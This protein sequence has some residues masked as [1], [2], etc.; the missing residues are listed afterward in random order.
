M[1]FTAGAADG[2]EL[3]PIEFSIAA[4]DDNLVEG[5]EDFTVALSG[6]GSSTGADVTADT[7]VLTTDIEDND[8]A[9]FVISQD[10][11]SIAETG[12]TAVE[13]TISLVDPVSGSAALL[14][15]G[16]DASVTV[17][18]TGGSAD[19]GVDYDA[20]AAALT[21]AVGA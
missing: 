12:E 5:D 18:V 4:E 6:G 21:A 17:A 14:G 7:P 13:F 1:T 15:A 20:F 2:D 11:S 10:V 16:E 19:D 3:T 9:E 8:A